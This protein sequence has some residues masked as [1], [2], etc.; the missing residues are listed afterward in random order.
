M[1]QADSKVL[2]I[3][4]GNPGRR[5]DGL[6]PAFV[7][8][9]ESLGLENVDADADYQLQI[10]DAERMGRYQTVI[11]ADASVSGP[12]V[13]FRRIE[14]GDASSFS[15]HHVTPEALVGLARR[16]FDAAPDAYLLTMRGVEFDEFGESLG[17]TA[18]KNLALALEIIVPAIRCRS[19]EEAA[20]SLANSQLFTVEEGPCETAGM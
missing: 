14:P 13:G 3:G 19:F 16:L 20:S 12:R 15:T 10:E 7:Q 11:F 2:I 17:E 4:F 6:G 5:D 1:N 9:V 18:R 8:A